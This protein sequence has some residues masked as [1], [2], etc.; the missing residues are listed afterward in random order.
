MV[1]KIESK[2]NKC[3]FVQCKTIEKNCPRL[4]DKIKI[5][6][7]FLV[8]IPFK[9]TIHQVQPPQYFVKKQNYGK[10]CVL[11]INSPT[12]SPP[13]DILT[14]Q[15]PHISSDLT[16]GYQVSSKISQYTILTIFPFSYKIIYLYRVIANVPSSYIF[17]KFNVSS[18]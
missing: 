9:M 8:W 12:K 10:I 13:I 1:Q 3:T 4:M 15:K 2:A 11:H 17:F 16:L 5:I 14:E 18:I 7:Q 6:K